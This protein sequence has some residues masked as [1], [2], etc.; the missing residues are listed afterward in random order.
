MMLRVDKCS[1][2]DMGPC[3]GPDINQFCSCLGLIF[4]LD[5]ISLGIVIRNSTA[6]DAVLQQ[7]AMFSIFL[8]FWRHSNHFVASVR[9]RNATISIPSFYFLFSGV[10]VT[11]PTL[12]SDAVSATLTCTITGISSP[13]TVT[14]AWSGGGISGSITESTATY[15]LESDPYNDVDMSRTYRLKITADAVGSLQPT[16]EFTCYYSE[17][18]ANGLSST[19]SM[20][21]ISPRKFNM[22]FCAFCTCKRSVSAM[23]GLTKASLHL[24]LINC[25]IVYS[26][27]A[28]IW[29]ITFP[30][31]TGSLPFERDGNLESSSF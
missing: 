12:V 24:K 8:L 7:F 9:T 16:S 21:L 10:T 25:L 23:T 18:G 19:H 28:V 31:L 14:A 5:L 30:I 1:N 2:N 11:G 15:I 13:D 22:K 17:D 20:S 26:N 27:C 3:Q 4:P 29:G 6:L